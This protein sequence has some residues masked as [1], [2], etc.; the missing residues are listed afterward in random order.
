MGVVED[1]EHAL[2]WA[3]DEE[4]DLDQVWQFLVTLEERLESLA[5]RGADQWEGKEYLP[6]DDHLAQANECFL[7]ALDSLFTFLEE[8]QDEWLQEAGRRVLQGREHLDTARRRLALC[9]P[10]TAGGLVA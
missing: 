9:A 10:V 7:G 5:G 1:L 4:A 6:L 8:L 3:A 2:R